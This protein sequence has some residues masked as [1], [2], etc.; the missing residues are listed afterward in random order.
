[1][2]SERE[3]PFNSVLPGMLFEGKVYA[4]KSEGLVVKAA[5][6]RGYAHVS[7]LGQHVKDYTAG[8][9]VALFN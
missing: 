2:S 8:E 5:E 9:T 7:H 4:R 3:L 6:Q 1:M